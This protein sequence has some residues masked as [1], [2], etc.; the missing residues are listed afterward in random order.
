VEPDIRVLFLAVEAE[1]FVKIGGLGDVAGS[2]PPALRKL[3]VDVRLAL[4]MHASIH[5]RGLPLRKN[6]EFSLT[7]DGGQV[8]IE[9]YLLEI[10][11]L[12]VYFLSSPLIPFDSPVYSG[13]NLTDGRKFACFSLAALKLCSELKWPIDILHA[14]DW[15]TAI[16]VYALSQWRKI[17]PFFYETASVIGVHNLPYLG[18][19]AGSM[20]E[21]FNLLP[22]NDPSLPEWA[23]DSPLALGLLAGDRIVAVSPTYARE[24]LTLEYGSGLHEFLRKRASIIT[25]IL[26]GLDIQHWDPG[27]DP[28]LESRYDAGSL[29]KRALNKI[30]LQKEMGLPQDPDVALMGMVNRMD[31]QKG[32]DLV[33][34]ALFRLPLLLRD[35]ISSWQMVILGKGDPQI[36]ARTRELE[37]DFPARVRVITRFDDRLSRLIYGGADM[38]VIPSR[39]EPCGLAQMIAMRYGCVPIGRATGGLHD[40]IYDYNH[41][42][43]STGFLFDEASPE[44]LLGAL[45]R[46]LRV[47]KDKK[48]W[49]SLQ[50]RGME[51][52]FSW[53]RSAKEYLELYRTLLQDF[54]MKS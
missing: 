18:N 44:A 38:L 21:S 46:A 52:D 54:R 47:F 3:A 9:S 30:A 34:E 37:R 2:L 6:C 28:L 4:P 36:E 42:K 50:R 17:D 39:Y 22:V 40:T 26:N 48:A 7:Y 13:D 29:E 49:L 14:N 32:V 24:I 15:H 20:V 1:P 8:P 23:W 19:G 25:G 31:Y 41:G 12:T 45:T 11:G 27:T 51:Q 5:K 33:P 53:Q 43:D 16:A 10:D 35:P